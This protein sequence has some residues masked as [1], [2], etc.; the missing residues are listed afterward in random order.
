MWS[1]RCEC[2]VIRNVR[3]DSLRSGQS[4][5]CGCLRR[6]T[7]I[8]HGLSDLPLYVTWCDMIRRCSKR[9]SP[10]QW[11]RYYGRGI[12]VCQKWQKTPTDFIAWAEAHGWEPGLDLDRENNNGGYSPYNCRFVSRTTNAINRGVP[13]NNKSG[14]TGVSVCSATG[15]WRTSIS[16]HGKR[17]HLG[18]Y[19]TPELAVAARNAFILANNLTYPIQGENCAT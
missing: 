8:T 3:D 7:L 17:K 4:K 2:G 11:H 12:R 1:C 9:C 16:V 13:K 10:A 18:C 15:K 14:F 6:D 19:S 5:S